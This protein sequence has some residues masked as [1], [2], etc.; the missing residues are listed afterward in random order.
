M[1][2]KNKKNPSTR[3]FVFRKGKMTEQKEGIPSIM[4]ELQRALAAKKPFMKLTEQFMVAIGDSLRENQG[5]LQPED[6]LKL[7][8]G[9]LTYILA[10]YYVYL[11]KVA[12]VADRKK[13]LD[14]FIE[15]TNVAIEL[16]LSADKKDKKKKG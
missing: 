7:P 1:K 8:V 11:G 16:F 10:H 15:Q 3:N 2:D 5:T 9:A 4:T 14:D 6:T 12:S 13:F